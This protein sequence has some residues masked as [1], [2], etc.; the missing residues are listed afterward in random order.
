MDDLPL[1]VLFAKVCAF[2]HLRDRWFRLARVSRRWR[3]LA[4]ASAH[5]ERHIDLVRLAH[6]LLAIVYESS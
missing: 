6:T 3:E 1:E 4:L 2:V 5:T